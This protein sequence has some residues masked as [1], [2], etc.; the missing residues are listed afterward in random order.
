M[1][2]AF[3]QR[4]KIILVVCLFVSA[5]LPMVSHAFEMGATTH[6]DKM[7]VSGDHSTSTTVFKSQIIQHEASVQDPKE[8]GHDVENCDGCHSGC[9]N[10]KL[11]S[12]LSVGASDSGIETLV[13]QALSEFVAGIPG[14]GLFRP[15]KVLV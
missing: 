8:T 9:C 7:A 15:P 3:F 2:L 1:V 12:R 11:L 10:L 13:F 4:V 6:C 5:A 14:S